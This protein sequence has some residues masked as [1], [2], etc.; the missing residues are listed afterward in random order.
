MSNILRSFPRNAFLQGKVEKLK[1]VN[2]PRSQLNKQRKLST[3]LHQTTHIVRQ[4]LIFTSKRFNNI[5]TLTRRP[6]PGDPTAIFA[7]ECRFHFHTILNRNKHRKVI[8]QS[9]PIFISRWPSQSREWIITSSL[10]AT[11]GD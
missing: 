6:T 11:L 7:S 9:V 10:M 1:T 4:L 2:V 3:L 8:G 5:V